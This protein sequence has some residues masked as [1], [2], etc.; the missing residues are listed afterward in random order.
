MDNREKMNKIYDMCATGDALYFVDTQ[1]NTNKATFNTDTE[2]FIIEIEDGYQS[3]F[4]SPALFYHAID[5]VLEVLMRIAYSGLEW[6]IK[7]FGN[8]RENNG[9]I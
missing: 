5:F 2:V 1:G 7:K 9:N 3:K 4:K 8:L 6:R